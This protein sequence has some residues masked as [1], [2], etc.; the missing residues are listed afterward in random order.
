MMEEQSPQV[1]GSTTAL[2]HTGHQRPAGL[3]GGRSDGP[4]VSSRGVSGWGVCGCGW[5]IR[6][7]PSSHGMFSSTRLHTVHFSR[8]A[9]NKERERRMRQ[10]V[11]IGSVSEMPAEGM[12]KECSELGKSI[13]VARI[14]GHL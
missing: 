4:G 8:E 1:R 5:D 2:P 7:Q 12:A 14:G 6:L 9:M 11:R 10:W 3:A 13:C